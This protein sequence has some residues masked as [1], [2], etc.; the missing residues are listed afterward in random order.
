MRRVTPRRFRVGAASFAVWL[1]RLVAPYLGLAVIWWVAVSEGRK[2]PR[3]RPAI[4]WGVTPLINIK[5]QSR[6]VGLLGYESKTVVRGVY[7]MHRRADFDYLTTDIVNLSPL[8]RRLPDYLRAPFEDYW[9]FAWALRHFDIF[10]FYFDSLMLRHTPWRNIELQLLRRA[11]KKSLFCAY[12]VDV[13]VI[14]RFGNL[15]HKHAHNMEYAAFVRGEQE[16]LREVEYC[17]RHADYI[18][19]GCDWVYSMPRWDRLVAGHFAIDM[20]EWQ[21]AP[22]AS[23]NATGGRP[24]VVLHAPNHRETKGTRFLIRACEEL[25]AEGVPVELVL[26]EK[27][28]NTRVHELIRD[29]D[30]VADQFV[31]GWYAQFAIE[32]MS[33]EK[34]VMTYLKPDLLE[35]YTL[36]SYAGECP[37]VNTPP[38]EIKRV[39]RELVESPQ[40]RR[41]L[42]KRGRAY[43]LKNHSLE[44]VG[45][46][47]DEVFRTMWGDKLRDAGLV[48]AAADERS[49]GERNAD[50]RAAVAGRKAV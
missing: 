35:L 7:A 5:F 4:F 11:G 39:L 38:T 1:A 36:N 42:G 50:E 20:Q 18:I 17:S 30:I 27:V 6:A 21:P 10:S 28:A 8:L 14:S 23:V 16:V 25:K 34:P 49:A 22:A 41:E 32:G 9:T 26:A 15:L 43:V 44:S 19:G 47:F 46:M 37:I 45:R 33:M 31:I 29:C 13:Q 2:A 24:V 3:E 48:T 40:L 12:G